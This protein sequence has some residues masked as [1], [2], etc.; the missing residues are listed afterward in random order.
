MG[1]DGAYP[2]LSGICTPEQQ[3][4]LLGKIFSPTNM[5]TPSGICVVD[6]SAAY[7]RNDGYLND[8]RGRHVREEHV[9]AAVALA[10]TGPVGEGSVGGGTGM[11]TCDFKAGIGT[12]SR[13]LPESHGGYTLGVL[14]MS[15]FGKMHNLRVGG[16]PLGEALEERF[17]QVPRRGPAWRVQ[18]HPAEAGVPEVV[19]HAR[20][21]QRTGFQGLQAGHI[22][23]PA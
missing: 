7:Y 16:L 19:H 21:G 14:V 12:A 3:Q 1:L 22:S 18:G 4:I 15:N 2:L 17:A 10:A 23:R 13:K 5:W 11:V 20:R 8:I 9:R 6:Q